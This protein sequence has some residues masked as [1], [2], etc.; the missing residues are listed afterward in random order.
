MANGTDHSSASGGAKH[1]EALQRALLALNA[2]RPQETERIAADVLKADPRNNRALHLLG[3]ARLMQGRAADAITPLESAARGRHDP[4]IDTQLG[5]A[6]LQTGRNEDALPRLKRATKE[7]PPY[8]P[9]FRELGNLLFAMGR[10][11]EA[12]E[13][14]RRG[15]EIA[16]MMPDLSIQLGYVFLQVRNFAA[17]RDA[18]ARALGISPNAPDAL[19]GMAM[20]CKGVFE[21]EA[22]AD[23]FRRYLVTTPADHNAW[24]HLGHC[25][26]ELGQIDAGHEC[27]RSAAR[28]DQR[29]CGNAI[30]SIVTSGRGRFWLKP[31]AAQRFMQATKS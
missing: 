10:C 27:F 17:A 31:S 18:F 16:P 4:E 22:A 3:C 5:V 20:A 23:Y 29:H 9:A 2:Q 11:E 13:A 30:A 19:F 25:L 8:A 15:L 12:I 6:L 14:L 24:L 1:G 26:L 21:N 28:G 7:R